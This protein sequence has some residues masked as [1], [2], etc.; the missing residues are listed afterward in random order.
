MNISPFRYLVTGLLFAMLWS[1]A[2]AAGKIGLQS[3]EGLVL[4]VVRFL[5]AGVLLLGYSFAVQKDRLPQK[6]EWLPLTIFGAFNTTIYLGVFIISLAEVTAGITTISLAL[7]PLLISIMSALWLRRP[8]KGIEWIS[9]FIG[10][11]GVVVAAYP[12]L[13]NSYA[14]VTGLVLLAFCMVAYSF[15][16]VYY[17]TVSWKLSRTAING[18]QVLIGG[19]L[20]IPM[21][22]FFHAKPNNFDARFWLSIAWLVIPVS[23]GAVQLWLYLLKWDTVKASLWLFLCPIFGLTYASILLAEPITLFTVAGTALV[24]IALFLGQRESIKSKSA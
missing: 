6:N 7:N 12:L 16:S 17:S 2:S 18:W 15:G 13:V 21:A 10:I 11:A 20:L 14:T 1:S 3:A 4:F 23:V 24:L 5:I 9:I 19:I 8:V 22:W